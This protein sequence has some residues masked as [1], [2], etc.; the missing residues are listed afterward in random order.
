VSERKWDVKRLDELCDI[1]VGRTPRR[2]TPKYWGGSNVW[3]TIGEL[4]GGIIADSKEHISDLATQTCMPDPVP[5]GTLLFS[6]KLSIGKMAV[7][8]RPLY[9]NEAIAALPVRDPAAVSRDYLKYALSSTSHEGGANAAVL[10]R[11]LNKEK[12][13]AIRVPVPPRFEQD[14]I[15]A[16]LDEAAELQ[17][18][19]READRRTAELVP[20]IFNEMFGDPATNPKGWPRERLANLVQFV[21]GGTPAR[22]RPEYFEGT[23]PWAM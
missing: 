14:R 23:I 8:G 13:S 2:D 22:A 5:T 21:G 7:T 12:V 19:R 16:V 18:L 4:N 10:G 3:V 6:F 20:A 1:R 9:T 17:R 15:V 11:V